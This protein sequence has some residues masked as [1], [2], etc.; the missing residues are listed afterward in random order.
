MIQSRLLRR[1]GLLAALAAGYFVAGKLGL[2][3]AY[4]H[5]S[6]TV[7]WPP[8][9][10]TLAA[11]LLAGYDV[12]PAVLVGAFLVNITTAGSVATSAAIAVGN[13]LEGL[14]GAYLVNRFA[15]GQR[16]CERARD[17]FKLAGLAAL[18]STAVSA[19]AGVVALSLAGFA[20]WTDFGSIWSTWWMGDAVSDLVVAPAVLLWAAH[21]RVRWTRRQA[22]EAVALLACLAVV[23]IAVFDGLVP[24]KDKHYPL[25]FLCI[26]LL[27]WAAFR[28]EQR[29][30]ATVVVLLA[31]VAIWGT[32]RGY[33]P[34][35]RPLFNESLLLLQAFQGVSAV[36]TLVLAA[37]VAERTEAVDRL[38][39]LAVSDPL[40]GLSN[41]RQL[42]HALD[43]EIRRSSRTD[44]PFA[45]VL[46]DLDGLKKVNDRYGH[47]VGSMALRRVAE[48]LLGSCRGID[49]AARFG[50]DEF[51]LVL[52][53]TGGAAAWHVA[54]RV[55]DR[56][57]RDGAQPA[58]AAV[59]TAGFY[60]WVLLSL[61]EMVE[62]GLIAVAARR[63]GEGLPDAAARAAGAAVWY[64]LG[65][66]TVV[67]LL[68][69]ALTDAL[70]HLMGVPP[71]VTTLGRAYL[72]T[73]L[74]GGP[75]GFGFF[76]VE[77]TF[78]A[79]GDTRTPFLL[80]MASVILSV[81]R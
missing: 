48:A 15:R 2:E 9:G 38:R 50:G 81:G 21:P 6:A 23:G 69:F 41:Y 10:L 58:L 37:A 65:A 49:T 77:A 5:P 73:W 30:A 8:T 57:A 25:E 12:W 29:E 45:V 64:A 36:I 75:L 7:V 28:F 46:M 22:L 78:R 35:A 71:E 61:G 68:G 42:A 44:R 32:L 55:A 43:A 66:G 54:R 19:T 70:F 62:V 79:S 18:L 33:G 31:G 63:H 39:R 52:P 59:S 13:T 47:L 17:I 60:V 20:R 16:A 4:I 26:P 40:T 1:L 11:L 72:D 74:L 67:S 34:F 80:L 14:L 76:P 27:L 56:V 51:A 3:V 53:E 24:W